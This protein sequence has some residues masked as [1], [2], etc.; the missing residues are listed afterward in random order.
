[1]NSTA[2]KKIIRLA[3]VA[4]L[5]FL[6]PVFTELLM[7]SLQLSK[8]WLL[9]PEMG[10]YG[11]AALLIR[12]ITRRL[13]R[14]WGTLLILGI[15]FAIAEECAILQTSLT[16]Q[17]F[18]PASQVNFGWAYGVEWIYL[19]A[20]LWYES[21]YAIVLPVKLVELLFPKRRDD[22]WLGRRGLAI[23]AKI[24]IL[25]SVGV[26]WLWR[27]LGLLKYGA[28]T[29]QVPALNIAVAGFASAALVLATLLLPVSS[30]TGKLERRGVSAWLVSLLAFVHCLVWF[31][32]IALA[33]FP[34]STFPGVSPLIPVGVGLAW[35]ILGLGVVRYLSRARDW[36]DK[37]RLGL[38][39][40]A[41]LAS[42]AGGVLVVLSAA[43]IDRLGK[44][45]F[46]L[47]AILFYAG[48]AWRLRRRPLETNRHT[49]TS[50]LVSNR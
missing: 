7:G 26:W 31:V 29:Y 32:L 28:S 20:M 1:M 24:F 6:S 43:P 39:V 5:I 42:M 46:D 36:G 33:Y 30:P 44:L 16:P 35:V 2:L 48:L 21:V 19:S 49:Q 41:S 23:S 47:L 3:P 8:L 18:P 9:L 38:I 13:R 50:T 15:A 4:V 17:F 40:G 10:V 14:G 25:S 34:A 27:H 11:L 45:A 22:L 37:Q 12:E